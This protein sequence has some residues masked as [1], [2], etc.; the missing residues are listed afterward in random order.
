MCKEQWSS[1]CWLHWLLV[2]CR[3]LHQIGNPLTTW[4]CPPS[5]CNATAQVIFPFMGWTDLLLDRSDRLSSPS[6][7]AEFG[8]V[9]YDWS[10][11]KAQ[12]A[13]EKP[14]D[15]EERLQTQARYFMPVCDYLP[16]W[17][18]SVL[19]WRRLSTQARVYLCI[20]TWSRPYLGALRQQDI[21]TKHRHTDTLT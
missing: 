8:I 11:A 10:N 16:H 14:M 6:R 4:A 7:G 9:S 13:A 1:F 18:C 15:C 2:S 3:Q 12:W 5:P 17:Y 19:G 20:A 21:N